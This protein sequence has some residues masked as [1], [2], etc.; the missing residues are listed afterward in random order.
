MW[1]MVGRQGVVGLVN[2]KTSCLSLFG[3]HL[4]PVIKQTH[5]LSFDFNSLHHSDSLLV[6][7][8]M[9]DKYFRE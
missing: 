2:M 3:L 4:T 9:K 1:M 8:K 7:R 6:S 5:S